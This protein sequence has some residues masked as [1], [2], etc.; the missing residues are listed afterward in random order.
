MARDNS[1]PGA[2]L[3]RQWETLNR[4]PG[5]K[6]LFSL[7][8]G[9]FV[10]YTGSIGARVVDLRPGRARVALRERR[11]VRNHLRSIHAAALFNLGEMT[12]GL[13]MLT[14]LPPTVRGIPTGLSIEYPKKAR[15]TVVSECVCHVPRVERDTDTHVLVEIRDGAGDT[16][17]RVRVDWRLSP[18]DHA[19]A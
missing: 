9:R 17:A 11:K 1:A 5:G 18:R 4:F 14:A 3:R 2:R 7:L 12:S 8:L 6:T 13:A 16:V 19:T 10:P 15:G